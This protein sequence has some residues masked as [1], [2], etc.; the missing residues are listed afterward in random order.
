[1]PGMCLIIEILALGGTAA[2]WRG[3]SVCSLCFW[4]PRKERPQSVEVQRVLLRRGGANATLLALGTLQSTAAPATTPATN[5]AQQAPV[6]ALAAT[7][8]ID[9]GIEGEVNGHQDVGNN[10]ELML[11]GH[12]ILTQRQRDGNLRGAEGEREIE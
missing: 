4:W 9:I 8:H 3:H 10:E 1:M 7:Q 5:A 6:D 11:L 12:T 2:T